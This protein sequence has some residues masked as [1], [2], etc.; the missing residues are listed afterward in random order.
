MIVRTCREY[1][2][3]LAA[4]F[5]ARTTY[6]I[7][8]QAFLKATNAVLAA[9]G[10]VRRPINSFIRS[11]HLGV[12]DLG[13]LPSSILP[14]VSSDD[15]ERVKTLSNHSLGD[16]QRSGEI[17]LLNVTSSQ[18]SFEWQHMGYMICEMCRADF[19]GDGVEDILC[20]SY[21]GPSRVPLG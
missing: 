20:E 15:E 12:A 21:P 6:D 17:H 13:V 8:S 2:A 16:L 18:F 9:A 5:Y 10:S 11:P 3:S 7:K 1:R 4:G 19:D 14:C